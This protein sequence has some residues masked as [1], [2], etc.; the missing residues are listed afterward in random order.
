LRT[1]RVFHRHVGDH[2]GV[3]AH[4]RTG[5]MIPAFRPYAATEKPIDPVFGRLGVEFANFAPARCSRGAR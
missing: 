2:D 1:R 5:E 4:V 3:M